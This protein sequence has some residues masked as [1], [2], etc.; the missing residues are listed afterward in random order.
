MTASEREAAIMPDVAAISEALWE[1]AADYAVRLTVDEQVAIA[2]AIRQHERRIPTS[3]S[4]RR[5]F[6]D[7][8]LH[9]PRGYAVAV[10]DR[11][12]RLYPDPRSIGGKP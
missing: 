6:R 4:I 7:I 3:D 8:R 1:V 9:A 5:A 10:R 12:A 11:L 2:R